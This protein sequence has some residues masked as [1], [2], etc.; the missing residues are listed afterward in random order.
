MRPIVKVYKSP[1][2]TLLEEHGAE[3]ASKMYEWMY[4]RISGTVCHCL[5]VFDIAQ[6]CTIELELERVHTMLGEYYLTE[7]RY[8]CYQPP[9]WSVHIRG[10]ERTA[11]HGLP[12]VKRRP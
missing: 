2:Y 6:R 4:I 3:I 7:I 11:R 12:V 9:N 1:V 8:A 10:I 5:N